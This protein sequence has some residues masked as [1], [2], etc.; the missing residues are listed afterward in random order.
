MASPFV[1]GKRD[2]PLSQWT[3]DGNAGHVWSR[4]HSPVSGCLLGCHWGHHIHIYL[5]IFCFEGG[6]MDKSLGIVWYPSGA[7]MLAGGGGGVEKSLGIVSV[8]LC[9]SCIAFFSG[10]Y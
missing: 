1:T 7:T 10:H 9:A 8:R 4:T 2:V 5:R 6:G 3:V